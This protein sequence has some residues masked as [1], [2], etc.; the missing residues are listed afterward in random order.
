[1]IFSVEFVLDFNLIVVVGRQEGKANNPKQVLQVA[2]ANAGEVG[3]LLRQ[4]PVKREAN[5]RG[6]N[7]KNSI[8]F[9]FG[10]VPQVELHNRAQASPALH[11][12]GAGVKVYVA[13]EIH[14]NHSHRAAARA[15]GRKVVDGRNLNPIQKEDVFVGATTSNN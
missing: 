5:F 11:R 1:M 14:I 4:G 6:P 15:L 10:P 7:L 13:N 2:T 8:D 12:E 3:R 9:F